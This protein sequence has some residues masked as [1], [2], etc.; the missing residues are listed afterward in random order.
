VNIFLWIVAGLL[1]AMFL[2]AGTLKVAQPKEKLVGMMKWAVPVPEVQLKALGL[3]ELLGAIGVILPR[4]LNI[5]PVLTPVAAVGCALVMTGA[6]IL[7]AVRKEYKEIVF[8]PAGL[9]ILAVIVAAG[10]F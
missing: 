10:R 3:V 6:V 8:P 9:L 7:H 2:L 4:A 5:A 1:A